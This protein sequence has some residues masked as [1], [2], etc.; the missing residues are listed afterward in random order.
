[1]GSTEGIPAK[2]MLGLLE[3]MFPSCCKTAAYE[4]VLPRLFIDSTLRD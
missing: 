3:Q 1:M 4:G 2:L